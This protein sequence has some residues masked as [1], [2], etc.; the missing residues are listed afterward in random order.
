MTATGAFEAAVAIAGEQIAGVG[1]ET[2][3]PPTDN[4]IDPPGKYVLPGAIDRHC[5]FDNAD[6]YELGRQAEARAG[7]TTVILFATYDVANR[8]PLP[9]T[10]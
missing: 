2:H 5:H 8:E 1:P 10:I 9:T 6:S 3:L 7:I 4:Y